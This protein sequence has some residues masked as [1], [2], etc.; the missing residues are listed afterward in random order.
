[1]GKFSKFATLF[2]G[3]LLLSY[4]AGIV[5]SNALITILLNP[6]NMTQS[7]WNELIF[8]AITTTVSGII[9]GVVTRNIELAAMTAVVPSMIYLLWDFAT[10]YTVLNAENQILSKLIFAPLL[11]LFLL[12][13]LEFWRGRD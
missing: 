8:L 11:L 4:F 2:G 5:D 7:L 1:M 12:V 6:E 3:V 10:L 9:V 13:A